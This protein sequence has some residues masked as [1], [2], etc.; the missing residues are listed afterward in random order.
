MKDHK[1]THRTITSKLGGCKNT[2]RVGGVLIVGIYIGI[3]L[4]AANV[5][6]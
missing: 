2:R 5:R 6:V 4:K 3:R 1:G